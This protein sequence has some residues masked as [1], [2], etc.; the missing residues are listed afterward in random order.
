MIVLHV[1]DGKDTHILHSLGNLKIENVKEFVH[2]TTGKS[3]FE[4]VRDGTRFCNDAIINESMEV[5]VVTKMGCNVDDCRIK[6]RGSDCCR[7]CL[8]FY[9]GRHRLPEEH[10]CKLIMEWKNDAMQKNANVLEKFK[11][12]KGKLK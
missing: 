10:Q 12:G 6:V 2:K 8:K 4:I 7:H 3:N 5:E 11:V 9:C 1:K